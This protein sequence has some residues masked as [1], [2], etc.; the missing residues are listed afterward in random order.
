MSERRREGEWRI[1][2]DKFS[3]KVRD[4]DPAFGESTFKSRKRRG[5]KTTMPV[6]YKTCDRQRP[7]RKESGRSKRERR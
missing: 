2:R 4:I 3:G 6:G 7:K 1:A 5:T